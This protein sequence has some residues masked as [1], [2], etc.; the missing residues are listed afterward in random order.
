MDV[1]KLQAAGSVE[2]AP[3]PTAPTPA[4]EKT[5]TPKGDDL[6][7]TTKSSALKATGIGLASGIATGTILATVTFNVLK[8]GGMAAGLGGIY[9]M[10]DSA[11]G[12]LA[13]GPTG[14][15]AARKAN[16]KWAAIALGAAAGGAAAAVAGGT[17]GALTK[18]SRM[19]IIAAGGSALAGALSGAAAGASEFALRKK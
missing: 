8:G 5:P 15:L 11:I 19:V 16:S 14:A 6:Q 17:I 2:T 3:K 1:P 9:L 7:L 12:G 10:A 4:A 13:G 18:D